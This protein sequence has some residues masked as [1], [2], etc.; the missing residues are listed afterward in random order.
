ME[1]NNACIGIM[2]EIE[3]HY[4]WHGLSDFRFLLARA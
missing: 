3:K 4:L 2:D 1:V